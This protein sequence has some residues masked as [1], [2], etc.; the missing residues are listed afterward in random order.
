MLKK[1][2][3]DVLLRLYGRIVLITVAIFVMLL[4][5]VNAIDKRAGIIAFLFFAIYIATII[6]V[7]YKNSP[8][9]NGA[10]V[11]YAANYDKIQN[12]LLKDLSIP[13]MIIDTEGAVLWANEAFVNVIGDEKEMGKTIFNIFTDMTV[14][15]LPLENMYAEEHVEYNEVNY[16]ICMNQLDM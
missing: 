5:G 9:F 8:G 11:K 10:I 16:K 1:I 2:K 4:I 7:I 15:K 6:Y 3:N 14:E 13:Y 12:R